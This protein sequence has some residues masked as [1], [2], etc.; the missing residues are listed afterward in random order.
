MIDTL[1]RLSFR[2]RVADLG[3]REDRAD[4]VLP[5]ALVYERLAV[6]AG[7]NEIVVP[8]VGLKDGLA[9]DLVDELTAARAHTDRLERDAVAAAVRLGRH[10]AFDEEHARQVAELALSIFDQ[11]AELHG[12]GSRERRI[13]LAAAMELVANVARYHRRS[14][15]NPSHWSYARL[16]SRDRQR[17]DRLAAILRVADALEREHRQRVRRVELTVTGKELTIRLVGEGELL[18]E[19]HFLPARAAMLARVFGLKLRIAQ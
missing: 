9:L 5:A 12:Y 6:L 3:L 17:V 16:N 11:L 2:Q 18:L 13:L 14:E 19:R 4:V 15:P 7:C 8:F 10:Y 1:A